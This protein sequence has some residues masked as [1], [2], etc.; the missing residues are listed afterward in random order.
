MKTDNYI[1][2]FLFAFLSLF[3]VA[4]KPTAKFEYSPTT[5]STGEVVKFDATKS[6]VYKAKEGNAIS[7]YAW[8]F[9]DGSQGTGATVEHTYTTAGQYT[10]T[11]KVADLAGQINSITKKITVKQGT[12]EVQDI[13]VSVQTVNG[14]SIPNATVTIQGQTVTTDSNGLAMLKVTIPQ[15]TQ[16]VVAKF[17]QTGFISQSIIYDVTNL[18]AVSANLLAIKQTV[19]V[20]DI[21]AAQVIESKHLGATITIPANAFVKADGS[22]ATGAVT[23][24]FT[25]WDITDSDLNAMPANGVARDAQGN[26]TNLISA[27]MISATFKDVNGQELQLAAGQKAD[28]QMN[29]PLKSINNQP[30]QV[31][32]QIP[33]WHFDETQGL[34]IEEGIGQVIASN[35]SSTGLAVHATVSHFSTWNWDFKFE[36]AGSVFVQCQQN[37][38]G[39]P[40]HVNAVVTL[41]D[42]SKVTRGTYLLAEGTNVYNMP[43][44]GK[45]HWVAKDLTGTLIGEK[46]SGTSGNVIIDLGKPT[47]D[48]IATC[49][50][51]NST[52]VGCSGKMNNQLEFSV[53]AEGGRVFT[54]IQDA[55]GQLDWNAKSGLIY[56]NN[57]WVRYSGSVTSGVTGAVDLR[58]TNREVVYSDGQGLS[59]TTVCSSQ[60]ENGNT[61]TS[62]N[63]EIDPNLIGKMCNLEVRVYTVDGKDEK[64]FFS[65]I[66][67]KPFKIQLPARYT[68]FDR[69]G[70]GVINYIGGEVTIP[71]RLGYAYRS[72]LWFWNAPEPNE[73]QPL[74]LYETCIDES[75][76]ICQIPQ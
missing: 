10:V 73:I 39:V 28:I 57:E 60:D 41:S 2:W 15:G 22:M 14:G 63:W 48:N 5:P 61:G 54:G 62:A 56:E 23:V 70:K 53:S 40:C 68:G 47:T 49:V 16:Q 33:M 9:G 66:Y 45:I 55:D 30:M 1:K 38:M 64:L 35:K 74:F 26:L 21:S 29:L 75:G 50:L 27:G 58:L 67:G 72:S 43:S 19:P 6:T 18:K 3:L 37:G 65:E 51:S 8:D 42:G 7:V 4:C 71:S 32:T 11:L 52:P 44:N 69:E 34:W 46:D 36:N 24:E 12:A 25:P 20:M 59:F 76:T 17:E 13:A 31:G